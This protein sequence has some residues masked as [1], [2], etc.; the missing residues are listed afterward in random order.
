MPPKIEEFKRVT[1]AVS[2]LTGESPPDKEYVIAY[3]REQVIGGIFPN[4]AKNIAVCIEL[5]LIGE[6]D[7]L[8]FLTESGTEFLSLGNPDEYELSNRQKKFLIDKCFLTGAVADRTRHIMLQLSPSY[9]ENTFVWN[10]LDSTPLVCDQEVLDML[11]QLGMLME[12]E[13]GLH[14]ER[15]YVNEVRTIRQQSQPKTSEELAKELETDKKIGEAAE[16]IALEF[17]K[18]RLSEIGCEFEARLVQRISELDVGAGFDI[19]SFDKQSTNLVPD[20]FIEVKGSRGNTVRFY[21]TRNEIEKAKVLRQ[22]Y[23]IYFI[24]GIEEYD[25]SHYNAPILIQ[26]PFLNTLTNGDY[27]TKC[28]VISV[29]KN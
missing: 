1:H 5:G 16:L 29:L 12:D 17:E 26:D 24:G 3:C 14:L 13:N 8:L 4:H 25:K 10:K 19:I 2:I 22:R 20:R 27:D 6:N 15:A 21:W 7:N 11:I 9:T 23:W 18:R 28:E